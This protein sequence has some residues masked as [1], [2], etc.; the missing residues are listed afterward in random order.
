MK[1]GKVLQESQT[2]HI[3]GVMKQIGFGALMGYSLFVALFHVKR[4]RPVRK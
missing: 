2:K 3:P 1:N 4:K